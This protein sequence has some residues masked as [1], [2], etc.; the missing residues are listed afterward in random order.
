MFVHRAA[1]DK[2][3]AASKETYI[4]KMFSSIADNYDFLN[5]LLSFN[6]DRYWRRFAVSKIE[7]A[8]GEQI[9]DVATG[10]GA[11]AWELSKRIGRG[12]KVVGVD[13]SKEMLRKAQGKLAKRRRHNL[14]LICAK[15][16]ALPFPHDTFDYVS[17][18]F[19]LRNVTEMEQTLREMTRVLKIGGEMLCLEFSQPQHKIFRRIYYSYIFHILPFLGQAISKNKEAYAY[20]PKS[21]VEFSSP[22]ELKQIMEKV[23]L[24]DIVAY[25][26][27]LGITTAH[28]AVKKAAS[29][30]CQSKDNATDN[31]QP[32]KCLVCEES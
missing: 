4:H 21:I 13:F 6:R 15:A 8:A 29:N 26:L 27:T 3:W 10:T 2:S 30:C 5:S 25:P 22:T 12:G 16:E 24:E 11:L 14:E 9:L 1:G 28:V 18:G 23:G 19:A 32:M 31:E 17:I 7:P 20:L